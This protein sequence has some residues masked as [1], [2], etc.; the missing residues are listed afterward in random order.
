MP[1]LVNQ[2]TFPTHKT[3]EVT[4][5]TMEMMKKYPLDE[6]LMEILAMCETRTENGIKFIGIGNPKEGKL[7]KAIELTNKQMAMYYDIEGVETKTEIWSTIDESFAIIG[8]KKPDG[9]K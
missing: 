9:L 4:N 8:E 1:Y 2:M 7:A 3:D 5:T 6:N